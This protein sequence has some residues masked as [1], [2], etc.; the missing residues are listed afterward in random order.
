M[1]P[2]WKGD[3]GKREYIQGIIL[4]RGRQVNLH[5]YLMKHPE[6]LLRGVLIAGSVGSGKTERSISVVKSAL[7][8]EYGVL[9]FDPSND[10]QRI[11]QE[12]PEGVVID[13]REYVMNPLEPPPGLSFEEL[14]QV[15]F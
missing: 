6:E 11:I 13:F 8:L 7:D 10:Y 4:N 1:E 5:Q 2:E 3:E 9:V 14:L 12:Y 15:S